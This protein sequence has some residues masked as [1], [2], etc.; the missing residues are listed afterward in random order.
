[1]SDR[2]EEAAKRRPEW[3]EGPKVKLCDGQEWTFPKPVLGFK[4]ARN[5]DGTWG[6]AERAPYGQE[7]Q[8]AVDRYVA[9]DPKTEADFL[10]MIGQRINLA[11]ELLF[12]NYD[13]T[14]DELI[15]LLDVSDGDV[16]VE[17]WQRIHRVLTF[18][19]I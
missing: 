17:M 5:P 16:N 10:Q 11:A 15:D 14:D 12:R 13:L 2:P 4:P 9:I 1:M 7:Y 8:D 19:S 6:A 18:Q 3:T